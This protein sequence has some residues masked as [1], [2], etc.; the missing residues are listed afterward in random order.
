MLA[1]L[2][3]ECWAAAARWEAECWAVP[4]GHTADPSGRQQQQQ[5]QQSW[6]GYHR[7]Q[8]AHGITEYPCNSPR[9]SCRRRCNISQAG[10]QAGRLDIMADTASWWLA[11]PAWRGRHLASCNHMGSS[12]HMTQALMVPVQPLLDAPLVAASHLLPV[13]HMLCQQRLH[14]TAV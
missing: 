8:A 2:L 9:Y 12:K 4:A 6:S 13:P 3:H 1:G 11:V 14:P 10:W 7:H 5:Q